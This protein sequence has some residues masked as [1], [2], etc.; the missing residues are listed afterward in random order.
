MADPGQELVEHYERRWQ[1]S[2]AEQN[3]LNRL[4]DAKAL[5]GVYLAGK[6][7]EEIGQPLRLNPIREAGGD[8][9]DIKFFQQAADQR[10]A[11]VRQVDEA[12]TLNRGK[13]PTDFWTQF[14][15]NELQRFLD[16]DI[17]D[18]NAENINSAVRLHEAQLQA[19]EQTRLQ[20][21][22]EEVFAERLELAE[23]EGSP[24]WGMFGLFGLAW[25]GRDMLSGP[26][27]QERLR[28][29][30]HAEVFGTHDKLNEDE[31]SAFVGT[32]KAMYQW[33]RDNE[34][35]FEAIVVHQDKK[36]REHLTPGSP[37]EGVK[38]NN[39]QNFYEQEAEFLQAVG[40]A[41]FSEMTD[42]QIDDLLKQREQYL[43]QQINQAGGKS[44]DQI[45]T[46]GEGI[47]FWGGAGQAFGQ[48][49]EK[50][51]DFGGFVVDAGGPVTAPF[52]YVTLPI[53]EHF[54]GTEEDARN[55]Q[56][57]ALRA[58]SG[59][60]DDEMF[61]REFAPDV[62]EAFTQLEEEM[63]QQAQEYMDI[64]GGD[65]I[66]AMG[67]FGADLSSQIAPEEQVK[68]L[69]NLREHEEMVIEALE[70]QDFTA[71]SRLL[72]FMGSL[73]RLG[74][75]RL[76]TYMHLLMD[77]G[78][79]FNQALEGQWGEMFSALENDAALADYSAAK[80]MGID[81]SLAGLITDFGGSM[82]FDP[83]TW[84]MGPGAG[85]AKAGTSRTILKT[86]AKDVVRFG[87]DPSRGAV[88]IYTMLNWVDPVTRG[89][90]I[91]K[92]GYA[93]NIIP[94]GAWADN[95][96]KATVMDR[97]FL[98][99]LIGV[100]EIRRVDV[101]DVDNLR[102]GLMERGFDEAIEVS[103]S[104]GDNTAWVSDGVKRVM[105]S[106]ELSHVPVR[107]R[108][109]DEVAPGVVKV[110]GYSDST[111]NRL[112][113]WASDK[114]SRLDG[115]PAHKSKGANEGLRESIDNVKQLEFDKTETLNV[116]M[117]DTPSG[118][119]VVSRD[120]SGG[121]WYLQDPELDGKVVGFLDASDFASG[122]ALKNGRGGKQ[123]IHE[124]L[125]MAH[126]EGFDLVAKMRLDDLSEA[127]QA[128]LKY[129]A[130]EVLKDA[131]PQGNRFGKSLDDLL[132]DGEELGKP[133]KEAGGNGDVF[134]RPNAVL[135][136]RLTMGE[137][138]NSDEIFELLQKAE[139]NGAVYNAG[140]YMGIA[141]RSGEALRKLLKANAP[142]R[143]LERYMTPTSLMKGRSLSDLHAVDDLITDAARMF[144]S[145]TASMEMH[146][147]RI[148][149]WEAKHADSSAKTLESL[150]ALEPRRRRLLAIMDE[151]GSLYDGSKLTGKIVDSLDDASKSQYRALRALAVEED[152]ALKAALSKIDNEAGV[153][154]ATDELAQI[155]KDIW[156]DF[157][158]KHIATHPEWAK[159]VDPETGMVPWDSL[160][161]GYKPP[162]STAVARDADSIV[163]ED[164]AKLADELGIDADKLMGDL[165]HSQNAALWADMPL[166]PL[167]MIVASSK[168]GAAYTKAT[169]QFTVANARN[170]AHS[171]HNLWTVDKVFTVATAAT[172]SFDEL[173]RI[174]HRF[175][176]KSLYR[177]MADRSVFL[178]ARVQALAHGKR[179]RARLGA[180]YLSV[181]KQERLRSLQ[182]YGARLK[183]LE[184]Q[185]YDEVGL[186]FQDILPNDPDFPDAARRWTAGMVQDS[187]F[188]SFLE[189]R[190][191][192]REWFLS[193][194]GER[195]RKSA[196]AT[197]NDGKLETLFIDSADD[198]YDGW[199]AV[200]DKVVLGPAHKAGKAGEVRQAWVD[201][202]RKVSASGGRPHD[203]PDIAINY[204]DAVRGVRREL[205]SKVGVQR[206]TETFF[207]K[208]FMNP[209]NYRRGFLAELVRSQEQARLRTLFTKQGKRVV[210]DVE[211]EQM[212]GLQGLSGSQ[213]TGLR[214]AIHKK[215]L[216]SGIIPESYLEELVERRVR[217]EIENTLY[218]FDAGSRLG[219]QSRAVFPFG[220]PW[221]DMAAFWGREM[222]RKPVLRGY[223]NEKNLFY[224]NS[225]NKKGLLPINKSH[226]MLSRLANTDF[227]IDEGI[228]G[229]EGEGFLHEGGLIPGTESTDFSPL[230]FLPTEGDNPFSYMIPGLGI[231]PTFAIAGLMDWMHDPVE[232]PE[233]YQ[234]F[235]EKLSEFLP[236]AQYMQGA[237]APRALG[238]GTASKV[239]SGIMDLQGYFGGGTNFT[240]AALTGDIS[241]ETARTR[242]ISAL[243][244]DPDELELLMNAE[245]IEEAEL[246]LEAL[247]VE[248]DKRASSAH[249]AE[250]ALRFMAPV[251][252]EF[253]AS[254]AEIQDVWLDATIFPELAHLAPD[255][256]PENMTHEQRRQLASDVRSSFFALENWQR[257]MLVVQQPSLAVNMVGSWEWTQSAVDKGVEGTDKTYRT[258]GSKKDL[259]RHEALLRQN[260]IRP[261]APIVRARRILGVIDAAKRNSAKGL[262]THQIERVNGTLWP[263]VQ[264]DEATMALIDF[265]GASQFGQTYDLRTSEEVWRHWNTLEEDFEIYAAEVV[266]IEATKGASTRKAD[267][268]D[269]D[270]LRKALKI[271]QNLKP[272]SE[273]FPGLDEDE[274]TKKFRDFPV[275][276]FDE[277][278][279]AVADA[280]GIEL[281]VGMLGEDLFA[282]IQQNIVRRENP[283][284]D[285]IRPAYDDYLRE[286]TSMT[287]RNMMYEAQQSDLIGEEVRDRIGEFMFKDMLM[288]ERRVADR[289]N[290]L[291][292]ADQNKMKEE[293]LY[294][295][296]GSKDQKTDW[297]GIWDAQYSRVYGPLDWTPPEPRSPFLED[298]SLAPDVE[299][300][301]ID[302]VVDGDTLWFRMN[303][304]S[305][306]LT[307]VRL[308]GLRAPEKSEGQIALDAEN[309]LKDALLKAAE[310]GDNIY[311]VRDDRFG[312]TDHYGRMLAWLWVGD[313]PY[314]NP[315]DLRPH[316]DPSGGS[317]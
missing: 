153:V 170:V 290:G 187:G 185:S 25:K 202:A 104:R 197:F 184:R 145:D 5:E 223:V 206:L 250:L 26:V 228:L 207:D 140:Q 203:L 276:G 234:A 299:V 127:G 82:V 213:R 275:L 50:A 263:I 34:P 261:T 51:M 123:T 189:G 253:D 141:R 264:E 282:Q 148:L 195:L 32:T 73:D 201:T 112:Q 29:D 57:S 204:L 152:R 55:E 182:D 302:H 303:K 172:V 39:F 69:T 220:K 147:E 296:N 53:I 76:N 2:L 288:K 300:P 118:P 208:L 94:R 86:A 31:I 121:R 280:L 56:L 297:E 49:V 193:P 316:Q 23:R 285:L 9:A 62:N 36:D 179:P 236:T 154:G 114:F 309:E 100:D 284:M 248:A 83:T 295:M 289:R 294:L 230:F 246:L 198:F 7:E 222:I 13:I 258:G 108:I 268:T 312:T 286:R 120:V 274:V 117:I 47:G 134:A 165:S 173:L 35:D 255:A 232:D 105:A 249:G 254:L 130:R 314:Y 61:R 194:D 52:K 71:G 87:A 293:F 224:L 164:M 142:G 317:E 128:T 171:L 95:A 298:G 231:V 308:L 59:R 16:Q 270:R 240:L 178:E 14:T 136:E 183:N 44:L 43:R 217:Q 11:F 214:G 205:P 84:L 196:V 46:P 242:Q 91:R 1:S 77:D 137:F 68:Y 18:N 149:K 88:S 144:G 40:V 60:P 33:M 74:P 116:G 310:N 110:P 132:I 226:M 215:A 210:T 259:A 175:G 221:A 162:R 155:S 129:H 266:G 277:Q 216:N 273:Q 269:F 30:V 24:L 4:A 45:L 192:F 101:N 67:F 186:G 58:E 229:G 79:Y 200:F 278:S 66:M 78:D 163:S 174:F 251:K 267:Q 238:G 17:Y 41:K 89:Q 107:I 281:E 279:I 169:H 131:L 106:D 245:S 168:G 176:A 265:V 133:L 191:A 122:F 159:Y 313:T 287:E 304:N 28:E 292:L 301:V 262:Y 93:D 63:P 65:R 241:R 219:T 96:A 6:K 166:S 161:R 252:N 90:V 99:N 54:A 19:A 243:L 199:S 247:S 158:R 21:K 8:P 109:T 15:P 218:Q 146:L 180:E 124:I 227:T 126:D 211:M 10:S 37:L 283:I 212:L 92:L 306:I 119:L 113:R 97:K 157:N 305:P 151:I 150:T 256:D 42:E 81:G 190:D 239:L 235:Q 237:A 244:A 38:D 181:K 271:P 272:W 160:Q 72:H 3:A 257:D 260:L 188:R 311:L 291:S 177:W 12:H 209:V 143:W 135:P 139:A 22:E 70:D 103:I 115:A 85:A 315:D 138:A 167:E 307:S 75:S 64:A 27:D 125:N 20:Q 80:A 111:V 98:D 48:V 233:G 102:H 156:E 225:L